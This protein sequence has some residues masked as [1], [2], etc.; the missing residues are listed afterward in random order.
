MTDEFSPSTWERLATAVEGRLSAEEIAD[1]EALLNN[2]APTRRAYSALCLL[3]ADLRHYWRS[4]RAVQGA[5][6]NIERTVKPN[7]GGGLTHLAGVRRKCYAELR[8]WFIQPGV[9]GIT[10]AGLFVTTVLLSLALWELP[11]VKQVAT[12]PEVR[13]QFVARISQTAR[14]T[15]T[16]ASVGNFK[17]RDLFP[18]ELVEL[19][20][21]AAEIAFADGARVTLV[22]PAEFIVTGANAGHLRR[23]RV[24]AIVPPPA[25]GFRLSTEEIEVVDLGTEF[26]VDAADDKHVEVH[27]FSGTVEWRHRTA[28]A[29]GEPPQRLASGT[30]V[31]I[32]RSSGEATGLAADSDGLPMR[33]AALF[34]ARQ[35]P[36]AAASHQ[37]AEDQGISKG[38]V[39][40]YSFDE[41][42][43]SVA[44]N[45][46][47]ASAAGRLKTIT[48]DSFT[49]ERNAERGKSGTTHRVG[50]G[51]LAFDPGDLVDLGEAV[52]LPAELTLSAWIK[53]ESYP[54]PKGRNYIIGRMGGPG[55][56]GTQFFVE[57][58]GILRMR[59]YVAD[60]GLDIASEQSVIELGRWHHVAAT[61]TLHSQTLYVDGQQ[62]AMTTHRGPFDRSSNATQIAAGFWTTPLGEK[63]ADQVHGADAVYDDIR[64][65]H[66]ALGPGD[67]AELLRLGEHD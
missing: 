47:D 13:P 62:V 32:A 25:R 2:D 52:P 50:S 46:I 48:A 8:Q 44:T 3:E 56:R 58:G 26:G 55:N 21:G 61:R 30:A 23:G 10:V 40:H 45:S 18:D 57:R 36:P 42:E 43:G 65:Y 24:V 14:A 64:V 41:S 33:E 19:K 66:R 7:P 34:A 28:A 4:Q 39:A 54:E 9:L 29:H 38:L 35:G 11:K 51:A 37:V 5:L 53:L 60:L 20:S 59:Q 49:L 15:W 27:V 12:Q 22:G 17:D 63:T 31:R 16:A 67:V 1:L 6:Q